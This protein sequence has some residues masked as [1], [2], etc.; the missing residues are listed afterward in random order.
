LVRRPA[1]EVAV[2]A[3]LV[4]IVGADD[5]YSIVGLADAEGDFTAVAAVSADGGDVIHLPG[6]GLVAVGV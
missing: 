6:A 3:G 2:D 5:L 1:E 4:A